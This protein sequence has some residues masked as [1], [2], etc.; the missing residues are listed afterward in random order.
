MTKRQKLLA[1]MRA[2]PRGDYTI[3]NLKAIAEHYGIIFRQPGTSHVTFSHPRRPEILT[4]PARRPI[5]PIYI[6]NFIAFIEEIEHE[7]D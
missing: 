1:R 5:K 2:N 3:E 4:V 6:K 7:K